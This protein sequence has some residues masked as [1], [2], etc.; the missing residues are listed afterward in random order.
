V[1]WNLPFLGKFVNERLQVLFWNHEI[2]LNFG[3]PGCRPTCESMCTPVET[4]AQVVNQPS[5]EYGQTPGITTAVTP[6]LTFQDG[7]PESSERRIS[8]PPGRE[9]W[10]L[11]KP[12]RSTARKQQLA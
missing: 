8:L 9:S 7:A 11:T 1:F 6:M 10:S 3:G 12:Y 5:G 2:S 4:R